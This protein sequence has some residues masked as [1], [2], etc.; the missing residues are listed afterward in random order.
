MALITAVALCCSDSGPHRSHFTNALSRCGK[1]FNSPRRGSIF[2]SIRR[3]CFQILPLLIYP[4]TYISTILS[5]TVR[6]FFFLLI[7]HCSLPRC[8]LTDGGLK[9]STTANQNTIFTHLF[10]LR[11]PAPSIILPQLQFGKLSSQ[12]AFISFQVL[13]NSVDF[14]E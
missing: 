5:F 2:E 1:L 7:S 8:L 6:S 10:W 13:I 9:L 12:P 11:P 4:Q 14:C 3:L